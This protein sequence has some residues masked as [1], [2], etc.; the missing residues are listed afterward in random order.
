MITKCSMCK[1]HPKDVGKLWRIQT[2]KKNSDKL[3][4]K[5][6]P[7]CTNCRKIIREKYGRYFI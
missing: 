5:V 7:T 3:S 1:G 6:K 2:P 4:K